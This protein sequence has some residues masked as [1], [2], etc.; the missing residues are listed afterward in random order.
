MSSIS[1]RNSRAMGDL[2]S[3]LGTEGYWRDVEDYTWMVI[4]N[5]TLANSSAQ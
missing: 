2:R 5:E 3:G 1:L 4:G